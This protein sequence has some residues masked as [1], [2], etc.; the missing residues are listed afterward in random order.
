[1]R[2]IEVPIDW[3]GAGSDGPL[4]VEGLGEWVEGAAAALAGVPAAR[5]PDLVY[6]IGVPISALAAGEAIAR[7]LAKPL[8]VDLGDP[9]QA[10]SEGERALRER[11]LGAAAGLVTTTPELAAQLEPLLA[12]G[13][14]SL[15]APAGGELRER[16]PRPDGE[17]P[18]F[19]HLGTINAG[20][21]DPGPAFAA[22]AELHRAERIEFRSHSTAW[23]P[24]FEELPHP[25]LPLL[26]HDQALDLLAEASAALVLGNDNHEQLPS[27][28]FEIACTE[29]WALC[30][31]ELADDATVAVLTGTGHGVVAEANERA[32]I[33][34]AATE[35]LGREE[36]GERPSP[37]PRYSWERR[38]DEIAELLGGID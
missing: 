11:V 6:A 36:R 14:P 25:H 28:A 1:M 8:V 37:E 20:R 9:W 33:S 30:V 32:A 34:A 16:R 18:L 22:L 10:G 12:E 17:P 13:T 15:L 27:K 24:D 5:R 31:S 35:I 2:A 26:P 29:T 23:H 19:V 7:R 38:L 21:V 4:N 3:D